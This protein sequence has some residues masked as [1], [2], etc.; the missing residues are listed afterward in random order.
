MQLRLTPAWEASGNGMAEAM[1]DKKHFAP[2]DVTTYV[3][4]GV[5]CSNR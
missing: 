5:E 1:P 3:S 2:G 4:T